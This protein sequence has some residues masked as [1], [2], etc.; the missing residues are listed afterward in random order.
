MIRVLLS[1]DPVTTTE[2]QTDFEI[3]VYFCFVCSRLQIA[4]KA[5]DGLT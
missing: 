1:F 3:L 2:A 5:A 4:F